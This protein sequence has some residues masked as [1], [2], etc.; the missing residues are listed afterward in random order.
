MNICV[1]VG[2][3]IEITDKS[4]YEASDKSQD[5]CKIIKITTGGR[6]FSII[7]VGVQAKACEYLQEQD[8]IG[9]EGS[10]LTYQIGGT[11]AIEAHRLHILKGNS[12][13]K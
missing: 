8:R 3:V 5:P 11:T 13:D 1:L 2:H 10:I 7:A 6:F 9:V 12:N 4:I